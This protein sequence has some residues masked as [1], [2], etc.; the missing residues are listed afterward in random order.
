MSSWEKISC[1]YIGQD[2][3]RRK[4]AYLVV[5]TFV[6]LVDLPAQATVTIGR[7]P[8]SSLGVKDGLGK[9]EPLGL[10]CRWIGKVVFGGGHDS[11]APEALVIVTLG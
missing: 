4:I 2:Q 3:C 1:Q 8:S 5:I 10:V 9:L 11:K 7:V 6:P